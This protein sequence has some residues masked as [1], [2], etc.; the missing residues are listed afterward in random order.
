[1]HYAVQEMQPAAPHHFKVYSQSIMSKVTGFWPAVLFLATLGTIQAE[2]VETTLTKVADLPLV[3]SGPYAAS[4]TPQ[5][6]R[7]GILQI[8]DELWFTTYSGG[9]YTVG[10]ISTYNLVTG[11]FDTKHSF[12]LLDPSNP[13]T[14]RHDGY[15]PFKTR[16]ELGTDGR[17]YYSTQFGGANWNGGTNGTSNNGG[18]VGSFDPATVKTSG[19]TVHWNAGSASPAP[20]T[21]MNGAIYVSRSAGAASLYAITNSGGGADAYGSIQKIDLDSSGNTSTVTQLT[22]F[23]T[24]NGRL[25]QGGL[26]LV[27]DKIYYSTTASAGGAN[28]TLQSIDINT[29]QVAVLYDDWDSLGVSASGFGYN[30]P[31]YDP[32][33]EALYVVSLRDGIYK[34]DLETST[35]SRLPNSGSGGSNSDGGANNFADPILFGD[36]I[37]YITQTSNGSIYRYDLDLQQVFKLYDLPEYGGRAS[38]QSGT[39]S[40]VVED[41]RE[42]LYFL[43][44]ASDAAT[45]NFGS[46]FKLEITPVP[47]PS[48]IAFLV[49]A[50]TLLTLGKRKRP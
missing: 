35:A 40:I 5:S 41:G 12:G 13:S 34:W 6:P 46:L 14:A 39:L 15:N 8:G 18:A 3:G 2:N 37:Y 22:A 7:G 36:S 27:D 20:R 32:L 42:Y 25:P 43:T 24:T 11:V 45:N 47:E 28:F 23:T 49:A 4:E 16:L 29:N 48:T 31:V 26:L 10:T 9:A 21:I 30:T 19:V 33:R 50:G 17:V 38:N 44:A 1:M